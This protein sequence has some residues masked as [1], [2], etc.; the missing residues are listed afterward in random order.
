MKYTD[1]YNNKK[2]QKTYILV[3]VLAKQLFG[4]NRIQLN[5][6]MIDEN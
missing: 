6:K 5:A 4:K 1:F 3:S 2:S